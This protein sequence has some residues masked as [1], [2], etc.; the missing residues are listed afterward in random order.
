MCVCVWA[1]VGQISSWWVGGYI[2]SSA[3]VCVCWCLVLVLGSVGG[4]SEKYVF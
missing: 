1:A 2:E 4:Q 3:L